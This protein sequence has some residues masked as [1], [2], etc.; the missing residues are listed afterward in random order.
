MLFCGVFVLSCSTFGNP[1]ALLRL[2][3]AWRRLERRGWLSR[4]AEDRMLASHITRRGAKHQPE[5]NG[6][7]RDFTKFFAPDGVRQKRYACFASGAGSSIMARQ[8]IRYRG[9]RM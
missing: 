9:W 7:A 4:Q 6:R 2:I 1:V 5:S 3:A 8:I